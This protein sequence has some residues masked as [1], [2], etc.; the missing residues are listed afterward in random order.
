MNSPSPDRRLNAFRPDLADERLRGLVEASRFV[1]GHPA[2]VTAPVA[3]VH[4]APGA[5]SGIDTQFLHGDGVLVFERKEGWAW[6]Q[7]D[8]DGY[9]GYIAES[10]LGNVNHRPTHVVSIPRSFVYPEAELKK[11]PLTAHSMGARVAVA[12]EVE[13]RGTRY[14]VLASGGAMIAKHL[15]PIGEPET[16]YVSVAETFAHTPYLWGGASGF[17]IDCSGLVQLSMFM[18]GR[19][20]PRDTDMQAAGIGS[21]LDPAK[22]LKR[23][24]LVFWRGHVA[25]MADSETIIHANG[26]TMTVSRETL[27]EAISRIEPLYGRPT[28]FR[29]P[30]AFHG[31][32]WL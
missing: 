24:D 10:A 6:V 7:G 21:P 17:G 15:R 25:I 5:A 12:E 29:R 3:D 8:R 22:G 9:V 11:P 27:T 2:V 18:A 31:S 26:H 1:A 16:D 23:G 28:G 4:S 14:A 32:K 30:R 20:A 13:K 19:D